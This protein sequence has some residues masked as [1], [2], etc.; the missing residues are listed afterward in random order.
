MWLKI[1]G[2][3][4]CRIKLYP[5]PDNA[6]HAIGYWGQVVA[7]IPS[8]D[9]IIMRLGLARIVGAWQHDIFI[10]KIVSNLGKK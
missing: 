7:I 6:F 4:A 3:Y 10:N 8:H 5:I 1:P 9:L 2:E